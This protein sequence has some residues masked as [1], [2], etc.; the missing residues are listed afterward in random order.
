MD[1]P[2]LCRGWTEPKIRDAVRE[3][4]DRQRDFLEM[5]AR[6]RRIQTQEI[7]DHLGLNSLRG[8]TGIL[9]SWSRTVTNPM[10]VLDPRTGQPSW[11]FFPGSVSGGYSSY[12]MPAAVA[13]IVLDELRRPA[14][15]VSER[16]RAGRPAAGPIS[17]AAIS[18]AR[19]RG[20]ASD[21]V[22]TANAVRLP[23]LHAPDVT[24]IDT[25]FDFR[26]DA[27]GKD[28][29]TYSATLRRYHQ[30]L[31][32]KPLPDGV[33]FE[34]EPTSRPPYRF[35]RSSEAGTFVLSSDAFIPSYTR[36]GVP[37]PVIER[38]SAAEHDHFKSIGY[39]IGGLI[40]WPANPID[41]KWTINQARG[42]RKREI[43]DRMDLTLECIRRH[44]GRER[45]PLSDV[46]A[47]Y[48]DFFKAFVDFRGYVDFWLL[49]DMVTEDYSAV[50]FFMPFH[51]FETPAIP[52]TF[53]GYSEYRRRS[54]EF[55]E[56]RNRRI[57]E[58]G[59]KVP[60]AR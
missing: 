9:S 22:G 57:D 32:S 51:N 10:G 49:Q 27:N 60:A 13:E 54:I 3:S 55:V 16:P 25:T 26:T 59:I 30:L 44:Y 46:L 8:V 56:S 12:E 23:K 21:V 40:L 48:G 34:L 4:T 18:R 35:H 7:V 41:R 17:R 50:R 53:D 20:L 15:P 39:T 37:K 28:P 38:F 47:R 36:Y 14:G 11:P 52:Q 43:G 29:D 31:W 2:D 6:N 19:Q 5:L 1:S 45:S 42:C 24:S 58:L 33:P